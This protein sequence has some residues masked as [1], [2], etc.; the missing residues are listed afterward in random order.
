M[1]AVLL[2]SGSAGD[3]GAWLLHLAAFAGPLALGLLVVHR[4]GKT[5]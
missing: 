5:R 1:S 4:Y 3:V 2:A